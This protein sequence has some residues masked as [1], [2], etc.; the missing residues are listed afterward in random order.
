[1]LIV[2]YFPDRSVN[3]GQYLITLNTYIDVDDEKPFERNPWRNQ[4]GY[5]CDKE[6]LRHAYAE[7]KRIFG[8]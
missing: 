4:F 6:H 2:K 5:Y 3:K 1:M 7:L 8:E